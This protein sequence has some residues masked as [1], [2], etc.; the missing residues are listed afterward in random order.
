[1]QI[2][3]ACYCAVDQQNA[4]CKINDPCIFRKEPSEHDPKGGSKIYE[5]MCA[6]FVFYG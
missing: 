4:H 3:K 1:M 6:G 5:K 2:P